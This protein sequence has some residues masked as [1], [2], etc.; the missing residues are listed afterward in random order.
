MGTDDIL[1]VKS[2]RSVAT[3]LV[4]LLLWLALA[5]GVIGF[6]LAQHHHLQGS[7]VA[8]A[9]SSIPFNHVYPPDP[10]P[11][12]R[13][14]VGA[15]SP[16]VSPLNRVHSGMNYTSIVALASALQPGTLFQTAH[17]HWLLSRPVQLGADT[18]LA[19]VGPLHLDLVP[20]SFLLAEHHATVS[21]TNVTVEGVSK[22]KL[23]DISTSDHRGFID[24]RSGATLR[25]T[26]DHFSYLGY[27]GDQTYGLTM[28]GASSRSAVV[29]CSMNADYFGVY[30]GKL[31]GILFTGN[32]ITNSVIY[33][34]DPHTHDSNLVITHNVVINSGVHGIV[35]ADFVTRSQIEYNVVTGSHDHGIVIYQFS[36]DNIVEHNA[37]S[38]SFD[39]IVVSNSSNNT[40]KFNSV[41]YVHRFAIRLDG[42]SSSNQVSQNRLRGA[43]VGIYVYRGASFNRIVNNTFQGMYENIRVRSDAPSNVVWPNPGRSEL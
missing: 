6:V 18:S 21:L 11:F 32:R 28:D 42:Q 24:A 22:T 34:I 31:R 5:A 27:L 10:V 41:Q 14:A 23:A 19:L 17:G 9:G 35:V 12:E 26:N 36:N 25:L 7:N 40:I 3:T 15:S 29:K 2:R 13:P 1:G 4:A 38:H 30:I 16:Y 33:G 20:G 43:I 39:G 8:S 37:V